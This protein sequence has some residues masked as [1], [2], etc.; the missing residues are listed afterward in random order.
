MDGLRQYH[1]KW[2]KLDRERQIEY[3][4]TY[5]WNLK[6][7]NDTNELIYKIE[8]DNEL[9]GYRGEGKAEGWIGSLGLTISQCYI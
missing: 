8:T 3:D 6:T 7:E 1:T 2:S 9:N 5:M 4:I